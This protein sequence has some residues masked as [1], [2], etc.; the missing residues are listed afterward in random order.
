MRKVSTQRPVHVV[1][2][3]ERCAQCRTPFQRTD[4]LRKRHHTSTECTACAL[5]LDVQQATR[6]VW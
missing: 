5:R 6:A 2:A 3:S 1:P 4:P